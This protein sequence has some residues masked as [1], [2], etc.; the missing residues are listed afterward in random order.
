M[1]KSRV[2][3]LISEKIRYETR[4]I[5]NNKDKHIFIESQLIEKA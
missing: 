1:I 4:N 2:T 5:T 3:I